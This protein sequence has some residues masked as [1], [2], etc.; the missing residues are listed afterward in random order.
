VFLEGNGTSSVQSQ[1]YN[2]VFYYTDLAHYP[3]ASPG[4]I[5]AQYTSNRLNSVFIYNNT[6]YGIGTPSITT[7][8]A[9]IWFD[10]PATN[11]DVKNN[12]W[13]NCNFTAGHHN[14]TSSSNNE[15]YNNTGAGVP[16][17]EPSQVTESADPF[18]KAAAY[19]FRLTPTANAFVRGADLS[20]VFATDILGDRRG[21]YGRWAVGA[22][23]GLGPASPA[24]VKMIK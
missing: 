22:Y 1:I 6:F 23:E 10:V 19:D 9:Q 8:K 13:V 2:N 14:V 5:Y 21:G 3:N 18:V 20:S 12:L 16:V 11:V 4:V 17:G 24:N 7:A 15:Y